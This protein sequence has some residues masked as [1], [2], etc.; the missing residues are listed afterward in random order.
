[1]RSERELSKIIVN[2]VSSGRKEEKGHKERFSSFRKYIK[3]LIVKR[4]NKEKRPYWIFESN[5]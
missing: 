4:Q 5:Y 2:S 1:M 3:N